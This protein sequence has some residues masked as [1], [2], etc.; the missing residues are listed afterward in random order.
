MEVS[1][2]APSVAWKEHVSRLMTERSYVSL[3]F[4]GDS[5]GA[6][7]DFDD[8]FGQDS[9]VMFL[10]RATDGGPLVTGFIQE[11][12]PVGQPRPDVNKAHIT[13]ICEVS[14]ALGS[15]H[16]I[17]VHRTPLN[18]PALREAYERGLDPSSGVRFRLETFLLSNLA[19][20]VIHHVMTPHHRLLSALE[21][22]QMLKDNLCT[23]DQLPTMR[24]TDRVARYLGFVSGDVVE[25]TRA[26]ACAPPVQRD[27]GV[28]IE[29]IKYWRVVR[30]GP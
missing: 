6:A 12:I 15:A 14:A 20:P 28:S 7:D 19:R 18:A 10:A 29:G 8:I 17:F 4:R 2:A 25:I 9:S 16:V 24:S 21:R 13:A 22:D 30:D 27:G 11:P 23:V 26:P 1:R 3:A 5:A